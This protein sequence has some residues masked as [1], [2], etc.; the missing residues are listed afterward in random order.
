M[1]CMVEMKTVM[2]IRKWCEVRK[3]IWLDNVHRMFLIFASIPAWTFLNMVVI[4]KD[5]KVLG[6]YIK[7]VIQGA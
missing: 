2:T 1:K 3:I 6:T 7:L 4:R 5:S